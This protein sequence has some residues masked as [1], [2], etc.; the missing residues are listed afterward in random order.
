MAPSP[1][2]NGE[3]RISEHK[4]NQKNSGI[5]FVV[6]LIHFQK[7]NNFKKVHQNFTVQMVTILLTG[8]TTNCE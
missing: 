3:F 5:F 2:K 8:G 7:E 1:Q 4:I 6:E